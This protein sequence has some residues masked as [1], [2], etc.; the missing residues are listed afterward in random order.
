MI[1]HLLTWVEKKYL[2]S[3]GSLLGEAQWLQ[4]S[5]VP[6]RRI[7]GQLECQQFG[8]KMAKLRDKPIAV[9]NATDLKSGPLNQPYLLL[10]SWR[11]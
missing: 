6:V 5:P 4:S 10:Q 1:E 8:L 11:Y 3:I 2:E 7:S 9:K